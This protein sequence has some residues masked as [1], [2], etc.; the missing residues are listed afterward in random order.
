VE[1]QRGVESSADASIQDQDEDEMSE[2]IKK[3]ESWEQQDHTSK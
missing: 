1:N 2:P 3:D